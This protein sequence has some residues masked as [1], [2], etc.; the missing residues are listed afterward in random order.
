LGGHECC[1]VLFGGELFRDCLA[2]GV[3]FHHGCL[4]VERCVDGCCAAVVTLSI[5][6]L[7]SEISQ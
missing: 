3:E 5:H 1:I 7:T 4:V 6:Y 2:D